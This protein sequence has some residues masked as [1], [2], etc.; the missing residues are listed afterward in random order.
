MTKKTAGHHLVY[1]S[2]YPERPFLDR[3]LC[4]DSWKKLREYFEEPAAAVL[5]PNHLHLLDASLSATE[6]QK[7][8][9]AFHHQMSRW[10]GKGTFN[11]PP[12]LEVIP[13]PHHLK[14]QIRYVHLNPCRKQLCADPL[15]WEWSTHLDYMGA[16]EDAWVDVAKIFRTIGFP[17]GPSGNQAFHRYISSDPTV[18]VVGTAAPA[19]AHPVTTEYL[20]ARF[21]KV[22]AAVA[23]RT[24]V[25]ALE[26]KGTQR[27]QVLRALAHQFPIS[28]TALAKEFDVAPSSVGYGPRRD[29]VAEKRL[30]QAIRVLLND[31]RLSNLVR[32]NL[33]K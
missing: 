14:R 33:P 19:L 9:D 20:S 18:A 21:A 22:A 12:P 30:A 4:V 27:A 25:S 15:D 3:G 23:S 5:M 7:R 32:R 6:I 24:H 13:D 11:S 28:K 8:L 31:V 2:R 17:Q 16:A 26:T 10:A 1:R 29:I